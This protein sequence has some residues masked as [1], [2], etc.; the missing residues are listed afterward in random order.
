VVL[1]FRLVASDDTQSGQITGVVSDGQSMDVDITAD[2]EVSLVDRLRLTAQLDQWNTWWTWL[3]DGE[4]VLDVT[5]MNIG[6]S[7]KP[8]TITVTQSGS[9]WSPG[10][11]VRCDGEGQQVVCTSTEPLAP[12][13]SLHLRLHLYHLH[14][15]RDVVTVV[16]TLGSATQTVTLKVTPPPCHEPWCW[17]T[18]PTS[19]Q[20]PPTTSDD[21]PTKTTE[22]PTS[23]PTRTTEPSKPSTGRSTPPDTGTKVPPPPSDT[24]V[25]EPPTSNPPSSEDP[26]PPTDPTCPSE[27]AQSGK[28][29]PGGIDLCLPPILGSLSGLLGTL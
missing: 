16:G 29:R 27:P 11:D 9:L 15:L 5:A 8:V 22:P 25:P 2:V 23:D 26:A 28:L 19:T 20:P 21:P 6:T 7:T 17:P 13:Q 24:V 12:K 14:P 3:W 4:P 10:K 1:L 18:P